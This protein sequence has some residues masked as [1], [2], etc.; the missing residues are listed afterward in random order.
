LKI[1]S[2]ENRKIVEIEYL[3]YVE[4]WYTD[5][6]TDAKIVS[7]SSVHEHCPQTLYWTL[8]RIFKKNLSLHYCVVRIIKNF[9]VIKYFVKNTK[10][11]RCERAVPDEPDPALD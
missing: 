1:G 5:T 2:S 9:L 10:T 11:R 6:N 4:T 8:C 7:F 3:S